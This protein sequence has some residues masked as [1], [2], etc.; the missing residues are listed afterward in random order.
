MQ[1]TS[2][3]TKTIINTSI[4]F[5]AVNALMAAAKGVIGVM[6]GSPAIISDGVSNLTD[7]LTGVIVLTG[8]K[9]S[10]K[11]PD[12][13][14]P[15]GYGRI[16]YLFTLI[17]V[18]ITIYG[19]V[20]AIIGGVSGIIHPS[21]PHYDTVSLIIV[22]A[23]IVVRFIL[24]AFTKKKAVAT[25]S[26]S[27]M[28]LAMKAINNAKF[29]ILTLALAFIYIFFFVSLEAYLA[30]F[31]GVMVLKGGIELMLR[32]VSKIVGQ[33]SEVELTNKIKKTIASFDGVY[34]AYDLLLHNYGPEK[35]TG[36]VHIAVSDTMTADRL[37]TLQRR[38]VRRVAGEHGVVLTGISIYSVNTHSGEAADV[39]EKVR[40]AVMAHENVIGMHGFYINKEDM[41]LSLDAVVSWDEKN[42]PALREAIISEAAAICPGFEINVSLDPDLSD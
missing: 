37:D 40:K 8:A 12:R 3:R 13:K 10:D 38:I 28:V 18:M 32:T 6:T 2:G 15:L 34:G 42:L 19:G 23:V 31:I 21:A 5:A 39:E 29:S 7:A 35:L 14:H 22:A 30:V 16:E 17:L 27:V 20:T 26:D 33:R 36:S 11:P 9:L 4:A 24:G 1:N 41:T 25:G